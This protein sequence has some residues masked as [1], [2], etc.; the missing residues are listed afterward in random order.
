[1]SSSS[2]SP[3]KVPTTNPTQGLFSLTP[4]LPTLV[5]YLSAS[6]AILPSR[7]LY[8]LVLIV[9]RQPSSAAATTLSFLTIPGAVFQALSLARDELRDIT[10]DPWGTDI[11]GSE[12]T[13]GSRLVF[14]FGRKDNWVAEATRDAIIKA[15]GRGRGEDWKPRMVVCESGVPH[16]FCIKHGEEMAEEVAAWVRGMLDR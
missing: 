6:A 12:K 8:L 13:G 1:M 3:Y 15:R 10:A 4:S 5:S 2:S 16:E 9:T 14:Y 11:W 7:L